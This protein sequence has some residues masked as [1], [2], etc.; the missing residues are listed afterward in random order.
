[1]AAVVLPPQ[2]QQRLSSVWAGKQSAIQ[3]GFNPARFQMSGTWKVF[4]HA[5]VLQLLVPLFRSMCLCS[6]YLIYPV[7]LL[8][9]DFV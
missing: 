8:V 1:V 2:Q 4:F 7:A 9:N 3:Q 5:I 6:C